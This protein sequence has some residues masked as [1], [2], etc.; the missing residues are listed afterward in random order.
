MIIAL[1]LFVLV[2]LLATSAYS[3]PAPVIH[4]VFTAGV[5]GYACYRIP[6]LIKLSD[7][8][9]LAFAEGRKF[10]CS[11]HGWNDLVSSR[12]IDGGASWGP[13]TLVYGES[14]SK[15][16]TTIGNPAPVFIL[17]I[18][19][20]LL[21]FS[22][23][24]IAAN[25]LSSTDKGLTWQMMPAPLPVDKSWTWVATGP[26]GS[27]VLAPSGRIIVPADHIVSTNAY[28]FAYFSDDNG[29]S[30]NVSSFIL[31]GDEAQAVAMPWISD[32]TL[33]MSMRS[34]GLRTRIA[35]RSD[36]GG[37]SWSPTWSTIAEVECE[38]SIVALSASLLVQSSVFSTTDRVNLSLHTSN[39][40]GVTFK[41][42]QVVFPGRAAYSSMI[43]TGQTSVGILVELG[44]VSQNYVK[45][46]YIPVNNIVG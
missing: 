17:S 6:A 37:K 16:N 43:V 36:D 4:D 27:L 46:S 21:P 45:I 18:S 22:R 13:V 9:F 44:S 35:S 39:D 24:N 7:T 2:S 12:S 41:L 29:N 3:A 28:S 15:I 33:L 30:W 34:E 25:V 42:F 14:S 20:I 5:G 8:E 31:H 23:N 26:P 10:T 19:T 1:I 11:D 32:T 38:G 40:N